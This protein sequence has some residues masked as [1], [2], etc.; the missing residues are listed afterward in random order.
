MGNHRRGQPEAL[1]VTTTASIV[2]GGAAP[3]TGTVTMRWNP[4][5][6]VPLTL[7]I[8]TMAPGTQGAGPFEIV[9][10]RSLVLEAIVSGAAMGC[11]VWITVDTD[12][13]TTEFRY[14]TGSGPG[15]CSIR[16]ATL[17]GLLQQAERVVPTGSAH[18]NDLVAH[19]VDAVLDE[20]L[21]G[22]DDC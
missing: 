12:R 8:A 17:I 5:Q 1:V 10:A 11:D 20:L 6:P 19:E 21:R 7:V 2:H 9:V 13:G 16:N 18:E 4:H 3:R 14:R 22:A 15:S